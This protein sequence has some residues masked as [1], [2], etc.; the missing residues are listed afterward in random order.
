MQKD[1]Y[2]TEKCDNKNG[3]LS[4]LVRTKYHWIPGMDFPKYGKSIEYYKNKF[5]STSSSVKI[6]GYGKCA[7]LTLFHLVNFCSY[8]HEEMP[9]YLHKDC[10]KPG[11]ELKLIRSKY[12]RIMKPL[13]VFTQ[14]KCEDTTKI[15]GIMENNYFYTTSPFR[16]AMREK[17]VK[18]G[19]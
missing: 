18:E 11:K 7:P 10:P 14:R 3:F 19:F 16:I 1:Y 8:L 15:L 2:Y 4:D 12:K 13:K 6:Q 17:I 9:Y 5:G